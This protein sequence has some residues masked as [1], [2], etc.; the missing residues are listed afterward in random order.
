M[1]KEIVLIRDNILYCFFHTFIS[2][3]CKE[4]TSPSEAE[5]VTVKP[6][7]GETFCYL[8]FHTKQLSNWLN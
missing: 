5:A 3:L 1:Y 4:L 8:V 2:K 6:S 7:V